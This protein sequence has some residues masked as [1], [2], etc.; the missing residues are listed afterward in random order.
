MRYGNFNVTTNF[1]LG[2]RI[3]NINSQNFKISSDVVFQT[4]SI[5][6][7]PLRPN[8]NLFLVNIT[9]EEGMD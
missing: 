1:T 4:I 2:S 8:S 6:P 7:H 9:F 5:N 3:L